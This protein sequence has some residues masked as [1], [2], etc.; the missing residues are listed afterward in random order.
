MR[1]VCADFGAR[2]RELNG[3]ADHVCL[4]V[5]YPPKV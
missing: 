1:K 5:D 4:V 2:R 3:E